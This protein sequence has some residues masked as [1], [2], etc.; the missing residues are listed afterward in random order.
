MARTIDDVLARRT[1]ALFL[2]SEAALAMAPAVAALMA[3][4]LRQDDAWINAQLAA[5]RSVA[6]GY[7]RKFRSE[8]A[9]K[10]RKRDLI[11]AISVPG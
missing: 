8:A 2:N 10:I 9:V 7:Q 3:S 1:R 11:D 5:F 6:A 4:E